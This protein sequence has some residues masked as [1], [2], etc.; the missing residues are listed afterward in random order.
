MKV[1][2]L[3]LSLTATGLCRADGTTV[4]LSSKQRGMARIGELRWQVL[5]G[6]GLGRPD[7]VAIEDYAFSRGGHAHE[8]GELGGVVKW[9][10]I[11]EG[12]PYV[13]VGPSSLKRFATGKGNANKIEMGVAAAK[14]G[15]DFDGDDN[16]CDAWWLR[17]MALYAYDARTVVEG[18]P[19]LC[20]LA[21]TA[22]RDDAVSK[23]AWPALEEPA[24]FA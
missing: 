23:V 12:Q 18:E 22:Y 20:I 10:L 7:L 11:E 13:L 15:Q 8:A 3:D 16:Q 9:M 4:T 5:T 1:V 17:Q 14:L 19:P 24:C 21:P 6:L 2:G